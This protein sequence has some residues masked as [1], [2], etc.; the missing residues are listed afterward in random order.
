MPRKPKY[1]HR[2][3]VEIRIETY[4]FGML[5]QLKSKKRRYGIFVGT[6]SQQVVKGVQKLFAFLCNHVEEAFKGRKPNGMI[7]RYEA[8]NPPKGWSKKPAKIQKKGGE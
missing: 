6:P 7:G 3:A 8:E 2:I 5:Q 1:Y 4:P